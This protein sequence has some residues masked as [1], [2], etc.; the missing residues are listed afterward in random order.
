MTP[1]AERDPGGGQPLGGGASDETTRALARAKVVRL[2]AVDSTQAVA[3]ELAADG[4]PGGAA[5][6]ADFQRAGRGRRGH[7][8]VAPPGTSLLVSILLRPH[9][10]PARRPLLGY[11]AAVAV[12]ETLGRVAAVT[13]RLKWPND[14][15]VR[16]RKVAGILLE[17]RG[18][19]PASSPGATAAAVV[20]V[21]IGINLTQREFP[22]ELRDQAT[23]LLLET[24]RV[25]DREETLRVLRD[26]LDR[27]RARL[28]HDG[29]G[30]VRARWLELN[31]TVGRRVRVDAIAGLATDLDMDGAL[32]LVDGPRSW[33]VTAGELVGVDG[34][35]VG[36]GPVAATS[37]QDDAAR[38]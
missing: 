34:A 33:R 2:I 17:S 14:V 7:A 1:G 35:R 36:G 5:V 26:E 28:E 16:G 32:V 37:R 19:A 4:A 31:D 25:V 8:W 15:L 13:A 30:P 3:F 23:S 6:V 12:A 10:E 22:Q 38:R 27:W 21:G 29:F 18:A 11:A 20:V 24:G 9:L